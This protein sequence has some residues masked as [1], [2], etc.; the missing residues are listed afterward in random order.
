ER[1]PCALANFLND[2]ILA[3]LPEMALREVA[4]RLDRAGLAKGAPELK[5]S[6][7][8]M[9]CLAST[10]PRAKTLLSRGSRLAGRLNTDWFVVYVETPQEAP[11]LID[12]E[13]QRHLL[14]N[15]DK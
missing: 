7:R 4:E 9:V 5:A 1:I 3:T 12:S 10:P 2:Q 15:M 8:V 6:G 14:G 13:A 11:N